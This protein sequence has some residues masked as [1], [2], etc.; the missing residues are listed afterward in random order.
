MGYKYSSQRGAG[1]RPQATGHLS[2]RSWDHDH[3]GTTLIMQGLANLVIVGSILSPIKS[4]SGA[5][6]GKADGGGSLVVL[7]EGGE[8]ELE[9]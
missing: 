6:K 2:R 4:E 8:I 9:E 1:H 5:D 7:I 3:G